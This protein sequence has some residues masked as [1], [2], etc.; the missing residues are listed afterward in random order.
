M[1][2]TKVHVLK[3]AGW[4]VKHGKAVH[5]S[6][7]AT[8]SMA[9]RRYPHDSTGFLVIVDGKWILDYPIG[10]WIKRFPTLDAAL[11]AAEQRLQTA[12]EH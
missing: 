12:Q 7:R 10:N 8:V 5:S 4:Q 11:V 6:G 3:R 2:Q 9:A 1:P